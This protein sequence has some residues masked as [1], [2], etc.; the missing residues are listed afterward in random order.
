MSCEYCRS[1]NGCLNCLS[2][3]EYDERRDSRTVEQKERESAEY[4]NA[5]RNYTYCAYCGKT[6][7]QPHNHP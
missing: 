3:M 5:W 7:Q 4:T 2:P 6:G 1:P